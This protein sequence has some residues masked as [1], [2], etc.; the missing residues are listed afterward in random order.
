MA[1]KKVLY[2]AGLFLSG[3]GL[4]YFLWKEKNKD[5]FYIK[6]AKVISNQVR[7]IV[8]NNT[9]EIVKTFMSVHHFQGN[10]IED[11]G[12][13]IDVAPGEEYTYYYPL[14]PFPPPVPLVPGNY[15][16]FVSDAFTGQMLDGEFFNYG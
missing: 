13:Y 2:I 10:P 4:G 7:A 14:P 15:L 3:L 12:M 1:F 16:F 9:S 6:E 8:V 5:G 11:S